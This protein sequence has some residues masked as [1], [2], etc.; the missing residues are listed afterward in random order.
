MISREVRGLERAMDALSARF[1]VEANNIANVNTPN[2]KR[3]DVNF[4]DALATAID[5]EPS[6]G[7]EVAQDPLGALLGP[8]SQNT[9]DMLE[10]F[11]PSIST[12]KGSAQRIDGNGTSMEYEMSQLVQT[13]QKYNTVATQI[14]T[15]YRTFKF[16]T[17][18]K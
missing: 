10:M 1:S 15:Q 9:D 11:Q 6:A 17:D 7:V 12:A 2:Y 14:A 3:Q 18:Q 8:A 13:T 16:I 4:E 5:S